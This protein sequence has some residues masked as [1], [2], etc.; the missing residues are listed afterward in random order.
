MA[1]SCAAASGCDSRVFPWGN[2]AP[3]PRLLNYGRV[4]NGT[5]PVGRFSPDG[6]SPY[7]AADMAGN[8]WEWTTTRYDR[9]PDLMV[10][11]G[12][13]WA[14]PETSWLRGSAGPRHCP[15]SICFRLVATGSER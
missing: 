7:G 13:S 10:L 1:A 15:A 8:V 14:D 11:K 2:G 4:L 5:S 9:D 12:G 6:D 3:S